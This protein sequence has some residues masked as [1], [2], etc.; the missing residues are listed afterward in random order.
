MTFGRGRPGGG[1]GN[2]PE[3]T[4]AKVAVT[5]TVADGSIS[6]MVVH[7]TGTVGDRDVDRTTTVEIKDVD[8][9]AADVPAEAK[10]KLDGGPT[11]KP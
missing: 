8:K 6:K 4:D 7:A 1:G 9:T 2:A 5:F 3:V 11:T 10:A